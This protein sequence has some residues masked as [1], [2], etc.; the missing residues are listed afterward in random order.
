MKRAVIFAFLFWSV[1]VFASEK[2]ICL[3]DF[4]SVAERVNP[5]VVNIF[6]TR[7]VRVPQND[8]FSFFFSQL[9]GR[10]PPKELK[11]RSLGSGFVLDKE[12]FIATNY[13]VVRDASEIKVKLYDGSVYT[14]KVVGYD[15]G[16]DLALLKIKANPDELKPALLGDS[17]KLKIGEWVLAVGNPFGLS[18]T[19]TAGIVS[20]KGRILGDRAYDQFIQTDASINPGNSGGPLVNVRGEVVGINTAII[21]RAQGIGFAIPVN[22]AKNVFSQLK[23]TGRVV[24]G[25]F[26]VEAT[27]V[28]PEV[29]EKLH[30]PEPSGA[31]VTEVIKGS[32]AEKAGIKKG[33]VIVAF[34][35]K[36]VK[37]TRDLPLWVAETPPGTKV[38][39]DVIRKGRKLRLYV[40]LEELKELGISDYSKRVL[41]VLGIKLDKKDNHY[42]ISKVKPHSPAYES[43]LQEGDVVLEINKIPLKDNEAL[44]KALKR[45]RPGS[46]V[47]FRIKRAGRNLYIAVRAPKR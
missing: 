10:K 18:Y 15:P 44:D 27:D 5:S 41:A 36:K 40:V 32:P 12:G 7:V 22:L 1:V 19:V 2:C 34:G 14:A 43:G 46:F 38:P 45:V 31:L 28:T 8:V 24:R 13:H 47:L 42:V 20:A 9:Y 29:A 25:W 21:A 33:D 3:P 30:L 4:S 16:T 23:K 37:K 26:G 6:T 35:G 17:D 39:V 11:R